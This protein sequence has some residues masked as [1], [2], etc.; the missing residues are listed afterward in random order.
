[1]LEHHQLPLIR[2]QCLLDPL[3]LLTSQSVSPKHRLTTATT[4][5]MLSHSSF[6]DWWITGQKG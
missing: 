3:P 6:I 1:D 4:R 5:R 2:P